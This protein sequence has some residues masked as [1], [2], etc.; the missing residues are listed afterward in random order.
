MLSR[1]VT[2]VV[3]ANAGT[4]NHKSFYSS[5]GQGTSALRTIRGRGVWVA[6]FVFGGMTV[7]L[8]VTYASPSVSNIAALI[9]SGALLPAQTTNWRA[10]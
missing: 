8:T 4:H 5:R 9:A 7:D 2:L 3:P 1:R 10:G 6:A